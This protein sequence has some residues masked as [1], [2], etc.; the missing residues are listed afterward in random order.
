ML[1]KFGLC[2]HKSKTIINAFDRCLE[3]LDQYLTHNGVDFAAEKSAK[4]E[5]REQQR[6]QR[7]EKY[8]NTTH[9]GERCN[10]VESFIR[11]LFTDLD[12]NF[13]RISPSY[14]STFFPSSSTPSISTNSTSP[15]ETEISTLPFATNRRLFITDNS[16]SIN[17]HTIGLAP[18]KSQVGDHICILY[19]CSVPVVL[20]EENGV[21]T[22]VG[23]AYAH[24]LMDGEAVSK[25]EEGLWSEK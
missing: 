9:S 21:F 22:F 19:G 25:V 13:Q 5:M 15:F 3:I 11:T 8:I 24:G 20:R 7:E 18:I 4:F 6:T 12:S 1:N 23:E 2:S 16:S 17:K 10:V 14:F